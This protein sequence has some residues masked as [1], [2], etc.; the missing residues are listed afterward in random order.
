MSTKPKPRPWRPGAHV[1][2]TVDDYRQAPGDI[3]LTTK[4]F[5]RDIEGTIADAQWQFDSHNPR[6]LVAFTPGERLWIATDQVTA[7]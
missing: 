7:T 6:L 4:R 5:N 2:V 3:G 1:L